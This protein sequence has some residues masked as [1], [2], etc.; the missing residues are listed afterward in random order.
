MKSIAFAGSF[1]PIT[2]GHLYVI[3][4]AL[5][6]AQEVFVILA[7]NNSKKYMFDENTRKQ[8]VQKAIDTLPQGNRVKVIV[9]HN[10]YVAQTVKTQLH[11]EYLIRGIRS[12][13]DFDYENLI[14]KTNT[15]T[16]YGA[17][18]L[19][20][21]PPK[22]LDCVSSSFVKSLVGPIGWHWHIKNFIPQY[23]YQVWVEK[24]IKDTV[25]SY[26]GKETPQ[27]IDTLIQKYKQNNRFYHNTEHIAHCLQE[28]QWLDKQEKIN[29][30]EKIILCL[31]IL[32]HD[33]IYGAQDKQYTDEQLSA[34]YMGQIVMKNFPLI[35]HTIV[36]QLIEN[37]QHITSTQNN[38]TKLNNILNSIDLAI[39]SKPTPI[40]KNYC[41]SVRLEYQ[42]YNEQQYQTG[43]IKVLQHILSMDKIFK[44]TSFYHYET[45]ARQ[46][47]QQ[48][49]HELQNTLIQIKS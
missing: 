15:D 5:H 1:D 41:A 48:E 30:T 4:Q 32:G 31:A 42:Q 7:I 13:L 45:L 44:H 26:C 27:F 37:T 2:N 16:L 20:V 49:I 47:I 25:F 6:I 19:F 33:C 18:T 8:M 36:E 3:E 40:Y 22:E 9:S 28:L 38:Y 35:N 10:E 12:G 24:Y 39:L 29:E 34:K 43:R 11:C 23:T 17:Q 21:I 14:Q 46:N